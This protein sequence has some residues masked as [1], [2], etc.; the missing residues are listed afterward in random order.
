[1]ENTKDYALNTLQPALQWLLFIVSGFA[2]AAASWHPETTLSSLLALSAIFGIAW[3]S[4]ECENLVR[5]FFAAGFVFS[6]LAFYWLPH[7]LTLFGGFPLIVSYLFCVIFAIFSAGQ[8]ALCGVLVNRFRRTSL[9]PFSL[10]LPLAWLV[11]EYLYPKLFPWALAHPLIGWQGFSSL[12]EYVGVYPLSALLL[13]WGDVAISAMF[14]PLSGGMM[15]RKRIWIMLVCSVLA[16]LV[17]YDR[18]AE[19]KK[20]MAAAPAVNVALVQGNLTTNEKGDVNLLEANIERYQQLSQEAV[21]SGAEFLFWPES[22]MNSWA[23][24]NVNSVLG[25][26]FDPFPARTVPLL[27]GGLSYRARSPEDYAR[28]L[29]EREGESAEDL[30]YLKFNTAFGVDSSG[31]VHGVYHK[32]VL[33]PFGEYLPGAETFPSIKKLSPHTGDFNF[34]DK[35]QPIEFS[36]PHPDFP[37]DGLKLSISP[38]ICYEDLVPSLS[39]D[40]VQHGGELLVNLTNDAWY[41]DSAAPKQHHLIAMWRA[42]EVRRYLLRVTNTGFTAVVDPTGKTIGALRLFSE[43]FLLRAVRPLQLITT[44]AKHGDILTWVLILLSLPFMFLK[45]R[46]N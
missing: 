39:R 34:G 37:A 21:K 26:K 41:G 20:I 11:T 44:Y 31:R 45:D 38:L 4:R 19:I 43:D 10:H 17:G 40:A 9:E 42:I 8:F 6:L 2:F 30:K 14:V 22:V 28:V 13:W 12:A 7:T 23:P 32:R 1:M 36:V 25:T 16:L 15:L 18:V 29:R 5:R 24:E 35:V 33:M 27:Y 3:G 46:K